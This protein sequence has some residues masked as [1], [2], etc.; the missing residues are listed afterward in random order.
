MPPA[1][2]SLYAIQLACDE[3]QSGRADLMLAGAV[4]RGDDLFL[5]VGFSTLEAMSP[6]GQSRPFH[7]DA[8][9]LLPAEGASFVALKRLSDAIRDGNTI[10]GIIRGIGISNDGRSASL[11]TP[12]DRG[13][14]SAMRAAYRDGR[15]RTSR[16][17]AAGMPCHR[18]AGRRRLRTAQYGTSLR[19]PAR[20]THRLGEIESRPSP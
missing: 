4:S 18:H 15:H 13:Q 10:H 19:G 2:Q 7:K 3:L 6:T 8:D 1:L 5:H 11:M 14:E 9:G 17:F 20:C 16:N 12:S